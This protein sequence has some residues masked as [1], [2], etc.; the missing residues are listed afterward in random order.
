MS[1]TPPKAEIN[2]EYSSP[3]QAAPHAPR[4]SP[5]TP[6]PIRRVG[7]VERYCSTAFAVT[8]KACGYG[9]LLS[10]ERRQS[11]T[12][13]R[14]AEYP[15]RKFGA[16]KIEAL[17]LGRLARS[18]LEHQVENPLTA[19]LY[20]LLAVEDGAAVDVHVVFHARVHGRVGRELDRGRRL[21]A[22]YAAAPGGE[23]D[24]IGASGH[25]PRRRNRVVAGRIHEDKALL[26]DGFRIVEDVDEVG[27]AGFR[28]RA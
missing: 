15:G 5:R 10:Q 8:T 9:F 4:S 13:H 25:L 24:E 27:A 3:S 14:R 1:A 6:G 23:A 21:A 2:T 17:A 11:T 26:G 7:C 12:L 22:E 28:H 19:L 18:R 16:A 20:R